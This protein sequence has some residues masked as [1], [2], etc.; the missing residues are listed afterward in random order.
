MT[1][2]GEHNHYSLV[3][4]ANPSSFYDSD[5]TFI[6]KI[7][8]YFAFAIRSGSEFHVF[9]NLFEKNYWNIFNV[10]LLTMS[11]EEVT[12]RISACN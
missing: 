9:I 6:F 7:C 11:L 5:V 10:H 3:P 2:R 4:E 12:H 8:R 1:G